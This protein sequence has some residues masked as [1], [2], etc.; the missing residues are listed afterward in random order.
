[1]VL[2]DTQLVDNLDTVSTRGAIGV[3]EVGCG[4]N[5]TQALPLAH[6]RHSCQHAYPHR[7]HIIVLANHSSDTYRCTLCCPKHSYQS[8]LSFVFVTVNRMLRLRQKSARSQTHQ[9]LDNWYINQDREIITIHPPLTINISAK[10]SFHGKL[11]TTSS[12]DMKKLTTTCI[13]RT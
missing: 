6:I 13:Y 11:W 12:V 2:G 4:S 8:I 7:N 1:M 3:T 9:H 5:C 10:A